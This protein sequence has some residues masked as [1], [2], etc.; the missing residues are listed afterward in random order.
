M[1]PTLQR[2]FWPRV[3]SSRWRVPLGILLFVLCLVPAVFGVM[4]ALSRPVISYRVE[5]GVLHLVGGES[6]LASRRAIPLSRIEGSEVVALG[7]GRRVAGTGLPGLCAGHFRYDGL[8][9]VWQVTD[10]RREV[11]LLRVAGEGRP[12]LVS[13]P[14]REAFLAALAAGRDA[15]LSPPPVSEPRGWRLFKT[16]MPAVTV[17]VV[18][19]VAFALLAAPRRLRYRVDGLELEVQLLLWRKRFSIAGASAR[20]FTPKRAWKWAGTGMPGYF[21]GVFSVDGASTRVYASTVREEGVLIQGP[22]RVFVTPEDIPG[23]LGALSEQGVRV[24]G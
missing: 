24:D 13:P 4:L 21:A 22:K 6:L 16:A 14:D 18:A 12:V 23:F 20:R 15:D 10:C 5:G 9:D 8:G 2:E 7:R 17:P 19:Y 1:N 3:S 11:L